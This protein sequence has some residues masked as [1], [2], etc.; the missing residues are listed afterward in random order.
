MSE[1]K[2]KDK[3]I[4]FIKGNMPANM[5]TEGSFSIYGKID[6]DGEVCVESVSISMRKEEHME[7]V[8]VDSVSVPADSFKMA[9]KDMVKKGKKSQ[10]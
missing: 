1:F 4:S 7:P 6:E 8:C 10:I 3:V 2:G 9:L 5:K